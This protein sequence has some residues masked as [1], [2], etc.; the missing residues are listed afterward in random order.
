MR[1]RLTLGLAEPDLNDSSLTLPRLH[2]LGAHAIAGLGKRRPWS[3]ICNS[4][5]MPCS[6][7]MLVDLMSMPQRQARKRLP[8]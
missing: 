1:E 5:L 7:S 4:F 6:P 3:C 2:G 8:S